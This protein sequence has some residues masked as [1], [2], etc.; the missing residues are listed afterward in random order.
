[1]YGVGCNETCLCKNN[2]TCDH[3]TGSCKCL[4]GW[5]GTYCDTRKYSE[6]WCMKLVRLVF[7]RLISFVDLI[8]VLHS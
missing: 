3:V 8:D 5:N 1:M 2:A 7:A 4:D 6:V